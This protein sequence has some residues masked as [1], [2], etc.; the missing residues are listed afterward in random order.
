MRLFIEGVNA[1][2]LRFGLAAALG[3]LSARGVSPFEGAA[4]WFKIDGGA[5]E[6]TDE[7]HRAADAWLAAEEAAALMCCGACAS[8]ARVVLELGTGP[9]GELWVGQR[10]GGLWAWEVLIDQRPDGRLERLAG[11]A[12]S[13]AVARAAGA[14]ALEALLVGA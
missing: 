2:E 4:A 14:E 12:D 1:R 6:L 5:D 9:D 10:P 11:E 3:V 7:E 13:E 8:A